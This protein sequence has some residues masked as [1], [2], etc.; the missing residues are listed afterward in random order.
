MMIIDGENVK[1]AITELGAVRETLLAQDAG[2]LQ[3]RIRKAQDDWCADYTERHPNFIA[4]NT[5][6][7]Q[8][9]VARATVEYDAFGA[10]P[11]KKSEALSEHIVVPMTQDELKTF[12]TLLGQWLLD[13][14]RYQAEEGSVADCVVA[15]YAE[16]VAFKSVYMEEVYD[17]G[18]ED[19]AIYIEYE[20]QCMRRRLQAGKSMMLTIFA[21]F[22]DDGHHT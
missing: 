3:A 14:V 5:V 10:D 19:E 21:H 17:L 4:P 1:F 7:G 13:G 9:S 18:P 8:L 11:M 20:T 15:D 6:L 16:T 2:E 22:G 12:G